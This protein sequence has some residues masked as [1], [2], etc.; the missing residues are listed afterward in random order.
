LLGRLIAIQG[1]LHSSAAEPVSVTA[2]RVGNETHLILRAPTQKNMRRVMAAVK[3][4]LKKLSPELGFSALTPLMK[5]GC[6]GE[7]NHVG[8]IFPMRRS[9]SAFETNVLGEL[10]GLPGV[11][12]V[13]SSVLPEL[14]AAT[15]TYTIMANAHRIATQAVSA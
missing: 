1:Y 12:L 4:K 8:G 15:F 13:D 14:S 3:M 2:K 11:H 10:S 9:P 5:I 7:G 6:P